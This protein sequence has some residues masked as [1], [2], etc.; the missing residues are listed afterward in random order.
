MCYGNKTSRM[1]PPLANALALMS[2]IF[3][4]NWRKNVTSKSATMLECEIVRSS[5]ESDN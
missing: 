1:E 4:G 5:L 3:P 2:A